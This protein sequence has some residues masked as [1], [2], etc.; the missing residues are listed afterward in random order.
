MKA[1]IYNCDNIYSFC[2]IIKSSKDETYEHS[3]FNIRTRNLIEDYY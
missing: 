3:D 2:M 1:N